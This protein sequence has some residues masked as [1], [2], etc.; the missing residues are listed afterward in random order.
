M[1]ACFEWLPCKNGQ[2]P[3]DAVIFGGDDE[4]RVVFVAQ[5]LVGPSSVPEG[6]K[7][8]RDESF[9]AMGFISTGSDHALIGVNRKLEP[10]PEYEVN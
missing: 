3:E 9:M 6:N 8:A 7:E 4:G 5:A 1:S 10:F 2:I